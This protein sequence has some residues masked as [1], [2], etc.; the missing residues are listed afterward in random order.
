MKKRIFPGLI[1]VS[2]VVSI[3]IFAFSRKGVVRFLTQGQRV[4]IIFSGSPPKA[5]NSIF[6]ASYVPETRR[7]SLIFVPSNTLVKDA[8][9]G[10]GKIIYTDQRDSLE[11]LCNLRIPF[12]FRMDLEGLSRVI[13]LMGGVKLRVTRP[14]VDQRS[15]IDIPSGTQILAG[16]IALDYCRFEEPEFGEFGRF[17]RWQNFARAFVRRCQGIPVSRELANLILK[18]AHTNLRIKDILAILAEVKKLDPDSVRVEKIPGKVIYKDWIN[19]WQPDL[20][21][22]SE[23]LNELA[24]QAGLAKV[25]TVEVLNGCGMSEMASRLG[26][27]LRGQGIDVVNVGNAKNFNYRKTMVLART[28]EPELAYQVARLIGTEKV[29]SDPKD[30]S[31][32]EVTIIIGKD[33]CEAQ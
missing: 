15:Q 1:L 27:F 32:V 24:S 31:L 22:T 9:G 10:C 16:S 6:L 5:E 13:D 11:E 14:I 30:D 8:N 12:Y 21:K 25:I 2:M 26:M 33:Y 29:L 28:G 18:D 17:A 7:M 3:G 4:N 19:Y 20:E 23:L